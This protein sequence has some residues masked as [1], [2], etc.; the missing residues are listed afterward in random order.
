MTLEATLARPD[1]TRH[2]PGVLLHAW[3]WLGKAGGP[4]NG[5]T[6]QCNKPPARDGETH[7]L[8]NYGGDTG[9]WGTQG[10]PHASLD[11]EL[12]VEDLIKGFGGGGEGRGDEKLGGMAEGLEICRK[13]NGESQKVCEQTRGRLGSGWKNGQKLRWQVL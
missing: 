13:V 9:P 7:N 12:R 10:R 2:I 5:Q 6:Q 4:E 8:C 1:A 11:L 3:L